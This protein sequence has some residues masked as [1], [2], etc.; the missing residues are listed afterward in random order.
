ML[1][2]ND[3]YE[4][5]VIINRCLGWDYRYLCGRCCGKSFRQN[6]DKVREVQMPM[7]WKHLFETVQI[8][9]SHNEAEIPGCNLLMLMLNATK[10]RIK[11]GSIVRIK[12]YAIEIQRINLF[13]K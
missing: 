8:T 11:F 5:T 6:P 2:S 13:W 3:S 7:Y 12:I 1:M 9:F 10:N 4:A